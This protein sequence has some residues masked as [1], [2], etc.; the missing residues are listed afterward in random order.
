M[1]STVVTD[2]SG[3]LIAVLYSEIPIYFIGF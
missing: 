1:L 3:I 2:T